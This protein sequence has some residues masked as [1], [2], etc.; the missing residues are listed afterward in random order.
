MLVLKQP[1]VTL[2]ACD[3]PF[4]DADC[5]TGIDQAI[6]ETLMIPLAVIHDPR[7]EV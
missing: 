7:L 4:G 5:L 6:T 2:S 1:T 3:R